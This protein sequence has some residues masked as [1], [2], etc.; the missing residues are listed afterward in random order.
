[1]KKLENVEAVGNKVLVEQLF[2]EETYE[3]YVVDDNPNHDIKKDF[4]LA[5]GKIVT[6]T[7]K[8]PTNRCIT[9]SVGK[10]AKLVEQDKTYLFNQKAG[11]KL[12]YEGTEY[13][14]LSGDDDFYLKLD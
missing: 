2:D 12:T 1:M 5:L 6:K 7:R 8:L 3:D 13:L 4:S 10:T 9:I 14:L 11:I